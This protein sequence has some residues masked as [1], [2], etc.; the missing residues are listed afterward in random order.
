V[1]VVLDP[2]V[3]VSALISSAGP[4][5]EIVD[6]WVLGRFVLVASPA[7]LGE[8]TDVLAR[9]RFRRW[10]AIDIARDFIAGLKDAAVVVEDPPAQVGLTADP[11][12]DYLVALARAAGA[13]FLVS[14]DRHLTGLVDPVPPVLT[15]RQFRDR[16]LKS[17]D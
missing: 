13:D 16:L 9:P 2:N 10:V 11:G 15:P 1:R 5:R 12:D 14:G 17:P 7:L 6:E 4:S 8:L 3:L